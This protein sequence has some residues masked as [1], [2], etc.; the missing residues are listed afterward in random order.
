MLLL[1]SDGLS[2]VLED[3]ELL[4]VALHGGTPEESCQRLIGLALER[5]ATDNV[6]AVLLA[7]DA[8]EAKESEE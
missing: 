3:E 8:P 4:E 5:G 2:N 1:C 6:T 7:W